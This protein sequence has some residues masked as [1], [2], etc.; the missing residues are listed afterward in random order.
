MVERHSITLS[1]NNLTDEF[2][3]VYDKMPQLR[4]KSKSAVVTYAW[5]Q[6]VDR[7]KKETI[8]NTTGLCP[9]GPSHIHILAL[10]RVK[11]KLLAVQP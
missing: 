6:F 2:I 8:H 3:E 9:K 11:E 5:K 1:G 10:K 7:I 4:G